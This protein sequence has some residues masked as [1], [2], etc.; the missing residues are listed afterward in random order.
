[1]DQLTLTTE[2]AAVNLMLGAI[3]ESPVSTLE[4]SGLADVAT[5]RAIL[6]ETSREVQAR[7]W[8][9]NSETN[10]PL[11]R[12]GD[13]YIPV[14]A[15]VLRV[16][17]TKEYREYDVVQR[18]FRLYDRKNHSYAFDKTLKV[19][20]MFLL[21]FEELPEAARYYI[22]IR[23]ARKFVDREQPSETGHRYTQEDEDTALVTLKE[24]EGD[25][26]DYNMLSGSYSVASILAR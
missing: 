23:A 4:D 22:A 10:Y 17:T 6:S 1:L 20:I 12:D 19:D 18:G 24:A 8:D 26:G 7:G 14:P 11:P 16:D 13:N 25:T 5:A 3:A 2:L 15:N 21:P 9:F